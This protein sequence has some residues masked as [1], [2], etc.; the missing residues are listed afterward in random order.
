MGEGTTQVPPQTYVV[1][2]QQVGKGQEKGGVLKLTSNEDT[3]EKK[4]K[5]KN[6]C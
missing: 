3:E 1:P 2:S 6:K 5:K 4:N